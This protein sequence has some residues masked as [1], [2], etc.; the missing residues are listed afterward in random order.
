MALLLRGSCEGG[1][2]SFRRLNGVGHLGFKGFGVWGLKGL[3]L[4][5]V[6]FDGLGA[7][8]LREGIAGVS[9]QLSD[10]ARSYRDPL[11]APT[12][13]WH[14]NLPAKRNYIFVS[15]PYRC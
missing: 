1:G 11:N 12:T 13:V 8:S 10:L 9:C 2:A 6:W 14:H 7:I 4:A 3:R 5:I 15:P